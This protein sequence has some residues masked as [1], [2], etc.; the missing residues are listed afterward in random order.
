MLF[1]AFVT[2]PFRKF[3][4]DV[5]LIWGGPCCPLSGGTCLGSW[6]DAGA[7][8]TL[9]GTHCGWSCCSTVHAVRCVGGKGR[10]GG[11][12]VVGDSGIMIV[13]CIFPAVIR[14]CCGNSMLARLQSASDRASARPKN[15][16]ATWLRASL[17]PA[18]AGPER[19]ARPGASESS[20]YHVSSCEW[21]S[22]VEACQYPPG[23]RLLTVN[24]SYA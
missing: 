19:M 23:S 1:V 20:Q 17:F 18:P 10:M 15:C 12:V 13:G 8:S 21:Y 22:T 16:L 14:G 4:H 9:V 6:H 24:P 5:P 11:E 3:R 7:V 2:A